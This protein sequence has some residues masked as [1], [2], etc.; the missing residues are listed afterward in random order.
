MNISATSSVVICI[1]YWIGQ[2]SDLINKRTV[3]FSVTI[4]VHLICFVM[5]TIEIIVTKIPI[6]MLHF[7]QP[8]L[9]SIVYI[10]ITFL[11]R[12][13]YSPVYKVLDWVND[14]STAITCSLCGTFL[15]VPFV[16]CFIVYPLYRLRV[17]V[18]KKT[19]SFCAEINKKE[20]VVTVKSST[21]I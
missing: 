18:A 12:H 15:V 9:F 17:L 3:L 13:S 11:I 7:Y 14:P 2:A 1:L 21:V 4:H 20:K 5:S 16:H 6:R 10:T 8:V 19:S